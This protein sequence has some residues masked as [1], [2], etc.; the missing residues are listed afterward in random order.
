MYFFL[1]SFFILIFYFYPDF[2]CKTV[3]FVLSLMLPFA[4]INIYFQGEDWVNYFDYFYS[5]QVVF[6]P[7]VVFHFIFYFLSLITFYNY[8]L[9][10]F[11]FYIFCFLAIYNLFYSERHRLFFCVNRHY[12]LF[13][14]LFLISLGPTLILEQLRQFL[15]LIFFMYAL[16]EWVNNCKYR[17]SLYF[18]LSFL[19]HVSAFVLCLVVI[20]SC[21]RINKFKYILYVTILFALL[22]F[23]VINPVTYDVSGFEFIHEKISRYLSVNHPGFGLMHMVYSP[24]I[25]YYIFLYEEKNT[26]HYAK[27]FNRAAFAGCTLYF[28]S[29]LLPFLNRFSSY[30]I[31]V[32]I[33][34]FIF[35]LSRVRCFKVSVGMFLLG[36]II[37]STGISYYNN[38]ISPLKFYGV[39]FEIIDILF[40]D[41][42]LSDK[43]ESIKESN[44]KK[45]SDYGYK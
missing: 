45:M 40:K 42:S 35:D 20:L 11:L 33:M 9:S 25:V 18:L 5:G 3:S 31:V 12:L 27:I 22:L 8:P 19:S 16:S 30:F 39:K 29:L 10:I 44:I 37:L 1:V 26:G 36:A 43:Y 28:I 38:P 34:C 14:S 32:Y 2:R 6:F 24:Y 15:A 23:V 21:A 17:A 13:L 4:L 41:V 7:E